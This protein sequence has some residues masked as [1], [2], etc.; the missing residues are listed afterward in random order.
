MALLS[1][2]LSAE[3]QEELDT[4]FLESSFFCGVF[5]MGL[6]FELRALCL[7]SRH[8]TTLATPLVHFCSG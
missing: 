8:S 2:K 4:G 3:A 1:N 5:L 6:G 7:Q